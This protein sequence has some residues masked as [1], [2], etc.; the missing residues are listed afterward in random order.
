[1][2]LEAIDD[3]MRAL[4]ISFSG[5]EVSVRTGT[6]VLIA[7]L[8]TTAFACAGQVP[9]P[10]T[11][12][13]SCAPVYGQDVCTWATL[14]EAGGLVE[15]G[16]TVPVAAI[17]AAP[18]DME[19]VWPPVASAVLSMPAEVTAA[20]GVDHLTVYWEAHGHP[21]GPYLTP[22]FDFH[23]YNV[24]SAAREAIDCADTTK[25]AAFPAGYGMTDVEIP[26][27]GTL[28]GLCVPAMG[29]H[30]LLES[31]MTGQDLFSGTMV[32]G[33]DRGTPL[34]FEPMLT[35]ELLVK[36]QS[37]DLPMPTVASLPAGVRYP[38]R[39]RAEYHAATDSYR[40]TFSGI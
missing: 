34:F 38:Q 27:I 1:L 17:D 33:Y 21:P 6:R 32:I 8:T 23:F 40:F 19:M 7:A 30:A 22:H 16:A 20:A 9:E 12:Q 31:E 25:P 14:D 36:R 2:N 10:R 28:I 15:F 5:G 13:G 11:V 35:R 29:M 24:A 4:T 39:Y 3:K 26:G 37:F 18:H